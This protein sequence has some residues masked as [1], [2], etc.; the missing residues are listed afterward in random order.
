[1]RWL[2]W[3]LFAIAV[4][5][6]VAFASGWWA[7]RQSLP[8]L[9]GEIA[10]FA[11]GTAP[12]A[13][14]TIERDAAGRPTIT[15]T[16]RADL[17]W[18][19]GFAHGQDRFFQMDLSRRFAAGELSELFGEVALEQDK[20]ARRF[21]FRR[22]AGQVIE[23]APEA[24]REVIEAYARGVNA[25]LASLRARP[26][27]YL[28]LRAEPRPWT[29]EDSV[30]VIHSMW[31]QLQ[32]NSLRREIGRRRFENAA[33]LGATP[34]SARELISFVY[35]GHSE[36]D[37][38][39]YSAD[40]RCI[41]SGCGRRADVL[42]RPFPVLLRFSP[43]AVEE[44]NAAARAEESAASADEPAAPGSNGWA[45]AGIHTRSGVA[46]VANDMHLDIG[47]PVVWYPAR[48]RVTAAPTLDITGVTLP[49]TPAVAAGSNGGIAWGFTNSYG[50][51]ADV[52]WR[53]CSFEEF[54]KR[55]ERIHV[56]GEA[57][58]EVEYH[59]VGEGVVL[60][61]VDDYQLRA[62]MCLQIAWLAM[63]PEA[64]NFAMLG[65]ERARNVDEALALAPRVGIP[66]QNAVFGDIGGRIAW[67]L[68]GRVP[69]GSGPDRLFGPLEYRDVTDHPR[70][71]DP[72]VGRLWTANQRVV[73]GA[74][75]AV[76]GDDEVDVGAGGY[77]IG[78]RARQIRDGLLGLEHPATEADMLAVQLDS[79]GRFHAR[80]ADLILTLLD[81]NALAEEP[82]RREFRALVSDWK[83]EAS[84]DSVGYRL[85]REFRGQTLDSLWKWLVAAHMG[86]E[87]NVPRPAQFEAAGWRLVTERPGGIEPPSHIEWRAYLLARVDATIDV[88]LEQCG[89]LA[90]CTYGRRKPVAIRHPLSRALPLLPRLVDMPARE[91]PG[92]HHMP[93]V[94]DGHF[95]ASER[96]A[97]SPGREAEGYLQLPG[98]PSGHPLSPFY[99][100][101]FED[102][103]NGKPTPFLPGTATHRLVLH[104]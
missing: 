91:L 17:A 32:Y 39:N 25:G 90:S 51:F 74:L 8:Q 1:M 53:L 29:P 48:L 3:A 4:I 60:D 30:L 84:P 62:D 85:V 55:R 12:T 69:R 45:I 14:T 77:D 68:M 82:R 88:L 95:G 20:N 81:E 92:D 58:V 31:W 79:R 36:W 13:A 63:R 33:A 21:A 7:L 11:P 6:V 83:P 23:A 97:V 71:A 41:E 100:S 65:L 99:R 101:G 27:E 16:S 98:G 78:A 64:T 54:S 102:W 61:D 103:A 56:R 89:A 86:S 37:T 57:D 15:A 26:W 66:G 72:P 18:A 73:D 75:E 59:D 80:W 49:G 96:F 35:A 28:L 40:A 94:Q 104:P 76:L 44:G 52:R 38:P 10:A 43:S 22:V 70:L 42:T 46:L 93:R 87:P 47:V 19:T 24:E 5:A 67:T 9:D 2:R 50:D 34:E